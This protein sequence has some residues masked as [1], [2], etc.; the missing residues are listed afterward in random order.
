MN[1]NSYIF[2]PLNYIGG[3]KKLVSKLIPEFPENINV[4]VDLFSGGGTVGINA[5]ARKVIF[6]DNLYPLVKMYESFRNLEV[7]EIIFHIERRI[8]EFHLSIENQSGYIALRKEYN[9]HKNPLDLFVLVA[10]S[11]NHQIRFNSRHEFNNPFGKNRSQ[12]NSTMKQNLLRFL[13]KIKSI[14][15]E[16]EHTCFTSFN[17]DKLGCNDFVYCDPP[18]LIT[19]GVYNDGKRGFKGWNEELETILL[20]KLSYLNS[21][22][23]K[24][25]LSNVI[26]HKG[27]ENLILKN[28]FSKENGVFIQFLDKTYNNS[29]YQTQKFGGFVSKEVLITNYQLNDRGNHSQ[30]N[31]DLFSEAA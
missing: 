10:F 24:F 31:L 1:K 6:N 2:S 14:D 17:F 8:A 30:M 9:T 16:F 19:T 12:F 29:N 13:Q 11:F 21:R 4:F 15:V 23:I 25:A 5:N 20:D 7:G 18:Y 28:W 3:K 27:R 26:E 22:K